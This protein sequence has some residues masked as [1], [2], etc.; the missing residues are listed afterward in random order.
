MRRS[1]WMQLLLGVAVLWVAA[2]Q[3]PPPPAGAPPPPGSG[4]FD[5]RQACTV[6]ADCAVVQLA[7]CDHCNGGT[8]V[9]IHRDHAGEVGRSY[10]GDCEGVA[11]TLRACPQPTPVCSRGICGLRVG[12]EVSTPALPP[13]P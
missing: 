6:D 7:C 5:E 1:P 10:R 8:A 3:P 11:C 12:R 4:S 2:C 9:G 13:P